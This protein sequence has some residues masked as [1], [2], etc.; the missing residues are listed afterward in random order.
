[1]SRTVW[2]KEKLARLRELYPRMPA[3]DISDILGISDTTVLNKAHQLGLK[4]DPLFRQYGY[5]YRY[6]KKGVIKKP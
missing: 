5:G 2:T 3:S 4:R 6:V 1:M